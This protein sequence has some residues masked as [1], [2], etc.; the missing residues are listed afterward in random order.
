MRA[1][2]VGGAR[3]LGCGECWGVAPNPDQ[4]AFWKK[5]FGNPKTFAEMNGY[6]RCEVLWHTFLRK[7]GVKKPHGTRRAV[8]GAVSVGASPQTP[9]KGLF[10]KSPLETQKLL[11][12]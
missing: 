4:R 10:G 2:N 8:R 6:I 12:K 1:L 5:S 3:G 11:P 7:K 9:T